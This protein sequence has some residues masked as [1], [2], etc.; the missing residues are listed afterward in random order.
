[1]PAENSIAAVIEKE[2]ACQRCNECCRQA[3]Y[4]YVSEEE[5]SKAAALLS[6]EIHAFM[7][8]YCEI[9]DRRRIVL[10]KL[11]DE[12]CVFLKNGGCE[13][14][15]AKPLQCSAFPYQ[16]RTERSFQYCQGLKKLFPQS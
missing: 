14:H 16:W 1:M 6:L 11:P 4:V 2:F 15:A 3:G 9:L 5:C 13:I 7:D 10:K 8:S 12:T